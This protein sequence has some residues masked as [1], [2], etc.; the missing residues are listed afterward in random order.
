MSTPTSPPPGAAL[1]A[2][3]PPSFTDSIR[4]AVQNIATF[5]DTDI[6]PFALDHL[7]FHERPDLTQKA[8]E[9]LHR[10]FDEQL[11][12]H[13]PDNINTLS[14][15]GYT[16]FRWATQI[17]PLWNAYYLALVIEIAPDIE[18]ARIPVSEN[19][20]FSYRFTLSGANGRIWDE[21]VSWKAFVTAAMDSSEKYP[22]VIISDVSDFYSRVYHHRIENALKWLKAK[23]EIVS[24][25]LKLLQVFSGTV[26]YG[27]PVG[28]P[29]SRLL[30]ELSLNT[31]DKLLRAEG[32]RFCRYVDDYR[33]F[34]RSREEAYQ[35]LIFLSE[36]LFNEGLV[37]QRNKTRILTAKEF[38]DELRL[39][40]KADQVNEE[41][42]TDEERL[43]KISIEFDPYS[44][45][46]VEDYQKLKKQ[47]ATIDIG[48]VLAR[49]LEKSRIDANITK[50]AIAALRVVDPASRTPI[51][52]ALLQPDNLLTLAPVFP[53]LMTLLRGLYRDLVPEEKE[54]VD[55]ALVA[56]LKSESHLIRID[57]NLA[58]LIQVLRQ[59]STN[60]KEGLLVQ[61]FNQRP[62]PLI[63]REV[64]AAMAHWG[65]TYWLGDIK[66]RFNGS[67]KWERCCF[68][69]S[70]FVLGDEGKHWRV[71]HKESFDL[72]ETAIRDWFSDRWQTDNT[73]PG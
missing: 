14:P 26:S 62:N 54:V 8:L 68:I 36:K 40:L 20:V 69:V 47:V 1:L 3:S 70:S 10:S 5:G 33:I 25:I 9:S 71:H 44:E 7:I 32:V 29:A 16:G 34:C 11:A 27:L 19:S 72:M 55:G 6:F 17:D 50:Q 45:T 61:L 37:L 18:A 35:R 65:H 41:D 63:R 57:L 52:K 73:I 39:L 60:E 59:R 21:K 38:K 42:L 46:R 49:E 24:R 12:R 22:Y 58:Y 15:I 53:R 30:A 31:V 28:G 48:G 66:K 51:L 67:S 23:P 13:P 2:S 56:L 4:A 43:L 64:I